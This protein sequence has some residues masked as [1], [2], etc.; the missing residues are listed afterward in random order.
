MTAFL[1]VA[2]KDNQAPSSAKG[3][4]QYLH[5]MLGFM[6]HLKPLANGNSRKQ[7]L[8]EL[9]L[10]HLFDGPAISLYLSFLKYTRKLKSSSF[11]QQLHFIRKFT[12]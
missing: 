1:G 12:R 10:E 11:N 3:F 9:R 6:G 8:A 4:Q 2:T 7:H 5:Q